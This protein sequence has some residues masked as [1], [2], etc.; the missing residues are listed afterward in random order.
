MINTIRTHHTDSDLHDDS[1]YT[2]SKRTD[3][4]MNTTYLDLLCRVLEN[5]AQYPTDKLAAH[6]V[7][8][9]QL[10]QNIS[11]T[12]S[13]NTSSQLFLLPTTMVVKNL[14]S[15]IEN[16][17]ANLPADL[18]ENG[19]TENELHDCINVLIIPKSF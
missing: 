11:L 10:A 15:Q 7:K 12:L 8:V 1:F 17:K 14:Q 3:A 18:R 16:L 19:K 2:T 5:K 4:F 13:S 6:L 9:Q